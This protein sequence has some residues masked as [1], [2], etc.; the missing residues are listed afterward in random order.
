MLDHI[1]AYLDHLIKRISIHTTAQTTSEEVWAKMI[2][3]EIAR[4]AVQKPH[5]AELCFGG[6]HPQIFD[7]KTLYRIEH[8]FM[9]AFVT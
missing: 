5:D 6:S 9:I 1:F 4:S 8:F 7:N 3:N 2:R